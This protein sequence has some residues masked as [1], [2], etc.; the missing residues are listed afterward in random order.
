MQQLLCLQC[1][2]VICPLKHF[3]KIINILIF[4]NK[5]VQLILRTKKIYDKV[6]AKQVHQSFKLKC[7]K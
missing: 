1:Q 6:S 4:L 3:I 2:D 7:I 5:N